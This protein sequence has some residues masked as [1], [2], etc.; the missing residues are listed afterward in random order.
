MSSMDEH[1]AIL[2]VDLAAVAENYM[3]A[4]QAAPAQCGAVVKA[5]AYG[6]G[7]AK[8]APTLW[9]AGCKMFFVATL[10]EGIALRGLLCDA[11]IHIFN[12]NLPG[13][14]PAIVEHRL[15]PV[16]NSLEAI[17]RWL[18]FQKSSGA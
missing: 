5:D 8:V 6:L 17:H 18:S 15:T 12:G 3:L 2:S 4:A 13:T 1:G 9:D 14:E 7:M 11:E 10:E 16:L